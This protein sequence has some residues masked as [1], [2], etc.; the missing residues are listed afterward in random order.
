MEEETVRDSLS[1]RQIVALTGG[2]AIGAPGCLDGSQNR[3]PNGNGSTGGGTP[4][5]IGPL[6]GHQTSKEAVQFNRF[7]VAR[8]TS[9]V[10]QRAIFTNLA[11][12]STSNFEWYPIAE[13]THSVDGDGMTIEL[14]P[15]FTWHNGD[16]VVAEDL[17][18][19]L[20]LDV[21]MNEPIGDYIESPEDIQPVDDTTVEISFDQQYNPGGSVAAIIGARG[22]STP[23]SVF[24]EYL[25]RFEEAT[26][27]SERQDAQSDLGQFNWTD[28]EPLATGPFVL[29]D[30]TTQGP[31]Y[32]L[33]DDY[34]FEDVRANIE[35]QT[36]LD[37]SEYPDLTEYDYEHRF[38]QSGNSVEQAMISGDL[39]GGAGFNLQSESETER[40]PEDT[41][42]R[43]NLM[44]YGTGILFNIVDHEHADAYRDERVRKAFAHIIDMDGVAQQFYGDYGSHSPTY[45]GLTETMEERL[46]DEAFVDSLTTYETDLER[47]R[48]LLQ[49]AGFSE[50][51]NWWEKPDGTVLTARFVGPTSVQY[52]NR[53]FQ[54]AVSHLKDFGINAELR[55]VEGTSFFSQTIP[56]LDY[57]LTRGYYSNN[58][59]PAA[60][61]LSHVRFDGPDNED[62]AAYLQEPYDSTVVEVPPIGE[63]DSSDTIEIDIL[64]KYG[65]IQQA[66]DPEAVTQIS[67]ELSWAFNQTVPR[68]PVSP[69]PYHWF[70][71]HDDWW[72]PDDDS[73]LGHIQPLVWS[74]PQ[75]GGMGPK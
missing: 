2:A 60:W 61:R 55:S 13:R 29:Q 3:S 11:V 69:A 64:E 4:T 74:F 28:P 67:K 62:Y 66:V 23:E 19:S 50:G 57:G 33:Y 49:D 52:Y 45:S 14:L 75:F 21:F 65:E 59:A 10:V 40:F 8:G 16:P 1:R 48:E 56:N 34:P 68:L 20:R 51:S 15:S 47:A 38:F 73:P 71:S 12:N 39:D 54:V 5:F 41:E 24:Q 32:E 9:W 7:N 26:T 63:P 35:E 70:L 18:R 17:S 6:T 58:N 36:D 42:V 43:T 27:E 46:L 25:D 31:T 22:L 53:G 44:G 37:L 72:Y 30:I